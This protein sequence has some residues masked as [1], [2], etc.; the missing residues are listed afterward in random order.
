MER[1]GPKQPPNDS[2]GVVRSG[3][4]ALIGRPN[5]GKS[6]LMNQLVGTKVS[7]VSNKP[8]TTRHRIRGVL[9]EERGQIVFV[10]TPGVHRPHYRMNRRM[11]DLTRA[12]LQD[13]DLIVVLIDASES[14]GSGTD[15]LLTLLD[16]VRAPVLL[17]LNKVDKIE[18][19]RLLPLIDALQ[20]RHEF[21]D[22]IPLSALKGDNTEALVGALFTGLPVG[23]PLFP[24]DTLTDRPMRFLVGEL[25]REQLLHR[26][27]DELPYT[28]AVTIDSWKEPEGSEDKLEIG[29]TIYVERE[30]QKPIVIGKG[31]SMLKRVGISA[32]KQIEELTRQPTRLQL[33]VK[34]RPDWR[35]QPRILDE[36]EITR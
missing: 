19:P 28:T 7:I 36:L 15:Y 29:A 4:V 32:R 13:V 21:A 18:K 16:D 22:I 1:S 20:K 8:Q 10:D 31:G 2:A 17:V 6:T 27:H 14:T 33:W 24:E 35:E 34:V 23:P 3:T 9:T 26:T 25:V 11:M 12:T 5:A 30:T